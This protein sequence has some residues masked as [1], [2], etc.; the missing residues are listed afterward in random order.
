MQIQITIFINGLSISVTADDWLL[1]FGHKK[2]KTLSQFIMIDQPF[3]S[4]HYS[5]DVAPINAV[6][7]IDIASVNDLLT[8]IY[9]IMYGL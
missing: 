2:V 9:P 1:L 7:L 3:L 6:Q 4:W 5:S 8:I